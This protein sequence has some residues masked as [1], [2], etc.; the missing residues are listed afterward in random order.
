MAKQN[1]RI[2]SSKST[3]A[4]IAAGGAIGALA[5]GGVVAAGAQK[6]VLIDYNGETMELATYSGDVAGALDKAGVQIA[7]G[8]LVYPA[9]SENLASGETITVQTA[10]PVAVVV[11][12]EERELNSTASTVGD[13]VR[14]LD[15]I[16]AAADLSV[17]SEARVEEGMTVD[18]TTPKIVTI[19]DGGQIS[20]TEAAK[21]TV[22]DLLMSRGV[23]VDSF[24][25]VSPPLDTVIDRNTEIAIDRVDVSESTEIENFKA[26]VNYVEDDQA[27]A[28]TERVVEEGKQ[29]ERRVVTRT[30]TVNGEVE[31][32]EV[33]AEDE[34]R[35]ATAA[36]VA[37][38]TKQAP[39]ETT[40]TPAETT[41]TPAASTASNSGA[42]APSK[43]AA[44]APAVSGGS[45]WDSIAQCESGG[46]WSI[47]TGNGFSG[48]L[49]FHPQT[50]T[51]FGGGEYSPTAAGATREQQIAVGEKVQ[52]AQGWGAWPACTAKLGIR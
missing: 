12:G 7:D 31:S 38:G 47:N 4:R 50:W 17:D 6:D 36:T 37:R 28:G 15:G 33:V 5:I 30:T 21:K 34:V 11:D 27:E 45:V 48:G 43:P 41:V 19:N 18:V 51:A 32:T 26:P 24:D 49:Q 25:R 20:F 29:G 23:T 22:G 9:P 52:A 3:P 8:D 35:P 14:E 42:S 16:S 1:A 10:K 39:A 13:L 2:N 46:D 44:A 40:V